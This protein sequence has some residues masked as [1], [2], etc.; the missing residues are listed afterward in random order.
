[1]LSSEIKEQVDYQIMMKMIDN[2]LNTE[3]VNGSIAFGKQ[4]ATKYKN[5]VSDLLR[6]EEVNV[7][8]LYALRMM[9]DT[10][11]QVVRADCRRRVATPFSEAN[12]EMMSMITDF[13]KSL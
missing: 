10:D 3:G 2:V 12:D 4:Y 8:V 5:I 7:H 6:E 9:V 11:L 13:V 1:M